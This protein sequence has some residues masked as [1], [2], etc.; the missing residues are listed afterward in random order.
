M[1][2][3]ERFPIWFERIESAVIAVLAAAVFV[4]LDFDWWYLAALFLV[5]DVSM[6]GYVHSARVGAWT[7]NAVHSY[8]APA[9][10]G[11]VAVVEDE[12]ALAFLALAWG[13][14]I[15]VDR[16][17]GYGLKFQDRFTHTHLGELKAAPRTA[18]DR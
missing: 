8:A 14:H 4:E 17:L 9:T 11:V 1:R 18:T 13:F 3:P 12:R 2:R 5:F 7:Y 6:L 10:A 15:A 16:G